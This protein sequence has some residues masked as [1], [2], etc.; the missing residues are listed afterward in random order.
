MRGG[1]FP[2]AV[3]KVGDSLPSHSPSAVIEVRDLTKNYGEVEAVRG[4]SFEVAAGEVFALLGP[5]GAGKSTTVEIMEGHREPSGGEVRV[6][7]FDPSQ[8][9]RDFR[10]R[11]G[12]V[13]QETWQGGELTVGD[14]LAFTGVAYPRQLAIEVV[15]E[16]V[17]LEDKRK[18]RVKSLSGGERRRLELG[19]ALIGD[20]D[21][22]FLDEPTTGFDPAARRRAWETVDGLR[23]LGK[24]ILLTTHYMEEAQYLADR[25]AILSAG[26]IA[27]SGSLD[28]LL[29]KQRPTLNFKLPAGFDPGELPERLRAGL[30]PAGRAVEVFLE[31]PTADLAEITGWAAGRSLELDDLSV[32]NPSLEEIYLS[33][34]G[35]GKPLDQ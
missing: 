32:K 22:I 3:E 19:L 35:E 16:L 26:K 10:E 7:G 31:R 21:L 24:T 6:L 12:V 17:G 25:I 30:D 23:D 28:V 8:R 27:V 15:L 29:E 9:K 14:T 5:N 2:S 34:V 11:I 20:P 33:L 4:I 13:P 18:R 1:A